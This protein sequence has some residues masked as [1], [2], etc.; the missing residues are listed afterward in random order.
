MKKSD[1]K[2][3]NNLRIQNLLF[4]LRSLA[5]SLKQILSIVKTLIK[6]HI[7]L[8]RRCIYLPKVTITIEQNLVF[9][10]SELM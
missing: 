3:L 2:F 1:V 6:T 9:S 7:R 10:R 5:E 4:M 8:D